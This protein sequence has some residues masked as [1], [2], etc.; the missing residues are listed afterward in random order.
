MTR[1]RQEQTRPP[2]TSAPT[3]FTVVS[4]REIRME[5]VFDAPPSVVF[6]AYTDPKR[7]P[8]WWGPRDQKT[9]VDAMEVRPGG[10]WR[11]VH[12][13]GDGQE[14]AFRGEYRDVVPNRRLVSSFEFEPRPGHVST[15]TATFADEGGK[16]RLTVVTAFASKADRDWML[17]SGMEQGARETWERL[18]ELVEK[19]RA[20]VPGRRDEGEEE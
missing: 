12:T 13:D 20:T 3:S 10:K 11:F 19:A 14:A 15:D 4:D 2:S 9:R 8:H 18:A 7:I 16:T 6:K 1:T 5:R 17:G